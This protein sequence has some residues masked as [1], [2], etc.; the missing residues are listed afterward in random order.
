MVVIAIPSMSNGGLSDTMCPRFGKC[1]TIT[2]IT[3]ENN[4]IISVKTVKNYGAEAI[5]SAGTKAAQI[6]GVNKANLV[7]VGFLGPNAFQTLNSMKIDIFQLPQRQL[8]VKESI[9]MFLQGK[10]K[11]VEKS[12]VESHFGKLLSS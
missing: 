10:L 5:S 7:L 2:F 6:L 3:V 1:T 11:K 9:T 12:N 8:T 4:E